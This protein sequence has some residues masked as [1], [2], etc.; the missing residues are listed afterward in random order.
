MRWKNK[1]VR[2][3]IY[4]PLH[5]MEIV[6]GA[7][8]E[9]YINWNVYQKVK[10]KIITHLNGNWMFEQNNK[11]DHH[12]LLKTKQLQCLNTW[13]NIDYD[14]IQEYLNKNTVNELEHL[15]L[16]LYEYSFYI[17]P[18]ERLLE[19][20]HDVLWVRK[21]KLDCKYVWTDENVKELVRV[22]DLFVSASEKVY[23][24]EKSII[25]ELEAKKNKNGFFMN[26][27]TEVKLTPYIKGYENCR[28]VDC[29][30]YVLFEPIGNDYDHIL[31]GDIGKYC[32]KTENWNDDEYFGSL[33]CFKEHYIS[34]AIHELLDTGIWSYQDILKINMIS[35][36]LDVTHKMFMDD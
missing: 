9:G 23:V 12:T 33:G 27:C 16:F 4:E 15:A 5:A 8:Y 14:E 24:Y 19:I 7:Y 3:K 29:F 18:T 35:V 34:Y 10:N 26:Y 36:D 1:S 2:P 28:R 30:M 22:S 11:T 25:K 13:N 31:S 6:T 17:N 21:D 20:L 32:D